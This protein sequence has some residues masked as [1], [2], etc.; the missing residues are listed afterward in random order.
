MFGKL[1][2]FIYLLNKDQNPATAESARTNA[3][4]REKK[5]RTREGRKKDLGKEGEPPHLNPGN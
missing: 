5:E 1:Y 3:K 2:L 4:K